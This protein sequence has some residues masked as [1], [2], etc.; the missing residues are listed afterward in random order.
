MQKRLVL[1]F[2]GISGRKRPHLPA[3]V[4]PYLDT[5][6]L[7]KVLAWTR[8]RFPFLTPDE[9]LHT[10]RP[11]VLLTFDDGLANNYTHALPVLET[12]DA[13]AVF[14]VAT[15]HVP[16]P[17]DWLPATRQMARQG[18]GHESR[19]PPDLAAE[20]YHGLSIEQLA[21]CA[22][23]PLITIGSHTV[24]HP[25]LTRCTPAEIDRELTA[26]K[27][28]LENHTGHPVTLLAYPAGDYNRT[29]AE[30]ARAAGYRAAFAVRPRNAGLPRY[31]IPRLDLYRAH[32]LYLWLKSLKFE[33]GD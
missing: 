6:D 15:Q 31:E 27:T 5:G 12:F 14:F 22:R 24:S 21:A 19:V 33:L 28:F 29:V 17:A 20:F 10:S 7:A 13:P 8:R 23:H 2:H 32:P 3:E 25:L 30:R 16:D 11:G 1:L 9:F 18:W 26:S 4:Q